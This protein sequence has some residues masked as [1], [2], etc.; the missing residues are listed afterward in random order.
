MRNL[1]Y[2]IIIMKNVSFL[3]FHN[4][5]LKVKNQKSKEVPKL[6]E[7]TMNEIQTLAQISNTHVVKF[8]EML[9]SKTHYYFVYGK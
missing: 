5:Y 7:F 9:K 4:D 3:K 2:L 8:Y 6:E 1:N